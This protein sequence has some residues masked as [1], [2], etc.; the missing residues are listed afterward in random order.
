MVTA[1]FLPCVAIGSTSKTSPSIAPSG[2]CFVGRHSRPLIATYRKRSSTAPL[3][4][5]AQASTDSSE[6][7]EEGVVLD[8]NAMRAAEI[9][10]VLLGLEDFKARIIEDATRLAKKVRGTSYISR[11]LIT[12]IFIHILTLLVTAPRKQLEASL[13]KHP[14]ILKINGHID[15]LQE[16]LKQLGDR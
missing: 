10:E 6:S 8:E 7:A 14:D 2:C 9:H 11:I 1:A 12:I 3:L 5:L 16:E 15:Q 4:C 13:K